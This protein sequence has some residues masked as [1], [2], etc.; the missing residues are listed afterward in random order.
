MDDSVGGLMTG[1]QLLI[2]SAVIHLV[3]SHA[4]AG[5]LER[6]SF[7]GVRTKA[8]KASDAAWHAGHRAAYPW[9]RATAVTGYVLGGAATASGAV[10]LATDQNSAWPLAVGLGGLVILMTMLLVATKKANSAARAEPGA[11]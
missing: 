3:G 7:I 2:V 1:I 4:A 6:N 10:L 8:T 11:S 5:Q 9:L